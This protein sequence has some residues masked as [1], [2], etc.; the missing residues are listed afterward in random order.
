ME[1]NASANGRPDEAPFE[2]AIIGSGI[3][4][5]CAAIGLC[6]RNIPVTVYEQARELQEIGVGIGFLNNVLDCMEALDARMIDE[7]K[8]ITLFT[9]DMRFL[10][11]T[12]DKDGR[13]R[14]PGTLA[15]MVLSHDAL[16]LS[17]CQ[18][19]Q[20]IAA[21]LPL[22]P[23]T[24]VKLGKRLVKLEQLETGK[25]LMEFANGETAEADAV[26]GC[27][28]IKSYVR[29]AVVDKNDPSA[30]A[31]FAKECAYRCLIPMEKAEP[32]LGQYARMMH[33]WLGPGANIVSYPVANYKFLN[34]AAFVREKEWS[35][36]D[37]YTTKGSKKDL[38]G[39]FAGFNPMV[40]S[41]VETFPEELSRWAIFDTLDHPLKTYA[42]GQVALMGD[43][44]HASTPHH[45]AGAGMGVE[46]ALVAAALLE[47]AAARL[48]EGEGENG[49]DKATV[50]AE[51]FKAYDRA[52]RERSQWLVMSSR[53]Q[54]E[55][56]KWEIA[57]VDRDLKKHRADTSMRL[58][59]LANNKADKMVN[60]AV[61]DFEQ[62]LQDLGMR[63]K[64]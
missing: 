6:A 27:D 43:A 19:S 52:R 61:A 58:D 20:F 2:V 14:P 30:T 1:P 34:A 23:P 33:F 11:A 18:R 9:K 59:K 17:V 35:G 47:R 37:M 55:L 41:L 3:I 48:R 31:H 36:G 57:E 56:N 5:L 8:K 29:R 62:K 63:E 4:G 25:V 26:I 45:G 44:A 28:G 50:L 49:A 24:C 13:P 39:A 7:L 46:D 16:E 60:E 64:N 42:F 15:D 53:K 21:M 32:I 40:R 10:D 12:D 54:G 22:L 51:A 38:I